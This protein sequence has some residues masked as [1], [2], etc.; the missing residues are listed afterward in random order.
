MTFGPVEIFAAIVIVVA[1]IKLVVFLISPGAWLSFAGKVYV[2][3]AVTSGIS[4]ILAAIILFYLVQSG[5]TIVQIFAIYLFLALL[6]M[7]GFAQ[8][9]DDLVAWAKTR[10]RAAWLRE[11]WLALIVWIALLVWGVIALFGG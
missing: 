8:Y 3:P 9:G 1:L 11:Q 4:L 5:V 10:D 7:A 6:M 2:K